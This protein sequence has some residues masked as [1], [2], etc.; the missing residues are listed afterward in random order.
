MP[1][2]PSPK[3]HKLSPLNV[4]YLSFQGGGA[5]G[6]SYLGALAAFGEPW[7]G[8]LKPTSDT[9]NTPI[10]ARRDYELGDQILGIAGASAGAITATLVASGISLKTLFKFVS[11]GEILNFYDS[12]KPRNIPRVSTD[13]ISTSHLNC[14]PAEID[15]TDFFRGDSDDKLTKTL[16]WWLA[17]GGI[18]EALRSLVGPALPPALA[19]KLVGN[20]DQWKM[21]LRNLILDYGFFSGCTARQTFDDKIAA[22][23]VARQK[24]QKAAGEHQTNFSGYDITFD[25]F[26]SVFKRHLILTGTNIETMESVY[27]SDSKTFQNKSDR[28]QTGSFK[29]VDALRISMSFPGAF[30]P[31][32]IERGQSSDDRLEGTWID[33]GLLNN[34][35]IHAF[36]VPTGILNKSMLGLR[37]SRRVRHEIKN[38]KDYFGAIIDTLL[39]ATDLGQIRTPQEEDQTVVLDPGGLSTLDFNPSRDD[40]DA[41]ILSASGS[42][43]EYFG[44]KGISI[45]AA[46]LTSV[47]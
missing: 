37:L 42:V 19:S 15:A 9:K 39:S 32:K 17:S 23:V 38:I 1:V 6:A 10:F 4:K 22:Q 33:G 21:Y 27:F 28:I 12:P 7:I 31:V 16:L 25:Q 3:L 5:K 34:S 47:F 2:A 41:A 30:K 24:R 8:I 43:L 40:L 44:R 46:D 14:D 13:Q 29:V 35:P 20:P 45:I 11:S 36:D 26:F 18:S